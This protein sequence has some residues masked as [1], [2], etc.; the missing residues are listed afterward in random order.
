MK[1]VIFHYGSQTGCSGRSSISCLASFTGNVMVHISGNK[2]PV[3]PI[4]KKKQIQYPF[5]T[6]FHH[7]YGFLFCLICNTFQMLHL[8]WG[9]CGTNSEHLHFVNFHVTKIHTRVIIGLQWHMTLKL[10]QTCNRSCCC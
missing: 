4:L 7:S 1:H 2:E 9:R 6:V 5:G 10:V 8:L 3:P